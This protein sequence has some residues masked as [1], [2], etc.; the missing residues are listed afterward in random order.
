MAEKKTAPEVRDLRK[1]VDALK[2]AN[3]NLLKQFEDFRKKETAKQ[4]PP[5][6]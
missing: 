1:E 5:L 2:K 6:L 4:A 3:E